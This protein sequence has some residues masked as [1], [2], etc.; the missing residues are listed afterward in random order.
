L[1]SISLLSISIWFLQLR[2]MF[3]V[4]ITHDNLNVNFRML[5]LFNPFCVRS[6]QNCKLFQNRDCGET[7]IYKYC[8]GNGLTCDTLFECEII[9]LFYG[10]TFILY[11]MQILTYMYYDVQYLK[12][13]RYMSL[14]EHWKHIWIPCTKCTIVLKC[15]SR[16]YLI[17]YLFIYYVYHKYF[18][19]FIKFK[20]DQT[21]LYRPSCIK[22]VFWRKS[23]KYQ[24]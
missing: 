8:L 20:L 23:K 15:S 7:R 14:Q 9:W 16:F 1:Y 5:R 17:W 19:C 12:L 4:W 24:T 21:F 6:L 22:F 10:L 2:V 11:Y 3:S 18:V 13:M